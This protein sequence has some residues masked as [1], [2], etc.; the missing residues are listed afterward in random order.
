MRADVRKAI[1]VVLAGAALL[2]TADAARAQTS[3]IAKQKQAVED[4]VREAPAA[5]GNPVLEANSLIAVKEQE[6]RKFQVNDLI[7]VIVRVQTEY[8]ADGKANARR[9]ADLKSELDAFIKLTGGG[10]GAT[11]FRR[12]K[13]NIDYKSTF[14]Q[15]NDAESQRED[16]LTTRITGKII[17]VKPNGNLVI[18]AR[19]NMHHDDEEHDMTLTGTCRSIDVTP[20]NTVLST[21]VENLNIDIATKGSIRNTTRPGWL[22]TIVDWIRPL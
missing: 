6:P 16:K 8:E 4:T 10:I 14:N 21:Q 11:P 7:T 3:S 20:D 12:G 22:S 17:D 18:E 19:S 9:Q 15:R 5:K 2:V 13:P 1:H